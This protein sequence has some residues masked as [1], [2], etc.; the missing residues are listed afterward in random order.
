MVE[1]VTKSDTIILG[2]YYGTEIHVPNYDSLSSY[3]CL[4]GRYEMKIKN[5]DTVLQ[6]V[7]NYDSLLPSR[8]PGIYYLHTKPLETGPFFF[9][10]FIRQAKQ[11]NLIYYPFEGSFYVELNK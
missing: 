8:I 10:G 4:I 3:S 11:D 1:L 5:I 7:S 9:T 6:M 2:E